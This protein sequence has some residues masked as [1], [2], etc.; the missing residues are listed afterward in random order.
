MTG[1][2]SS[3]AFT[4]DYS[5][6]YAAGSFAGQVSVYQEDAKGAMMH[7]EGVVGGGVTQASFPT[8]R[9]FIL[10]PGLQFI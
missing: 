7:L 8:L 2:I 10:C 9:S 3:I 5:G 1:I 4:T 6:V